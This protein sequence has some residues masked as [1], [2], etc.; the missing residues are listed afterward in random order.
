MKQTSYL[1]GEVLKAALR[2][3]TV[4]ARANTTAY[5]VGDRVM[6]G[7]ADLNV[8]E[9]IVAGNSAGAPPSFNTNIGDTTVDGGVT[10]LTLKQGLPKR[11]NYVGLFTVAPT[12]A[13][14]GTEVVGGSYARQVYQ[15]GDANWTAA[16]AQGDASNKVAITFPAPTANWG[17]VVAFGIFDR[18]TGGNLL[19]WGE[20]TS[21]LTVNNGDAAPAFAIGAV[22]VLDKVFRNPGLRATVP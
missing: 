2:T 16:T 8:Y 4:T 1:A 20:V 14:G 3:S 6:L 13:G 17:D 5:N 21:P 9:C 7:T 11:P 15:P 18:L 19:W 10:W 22:H 12:E